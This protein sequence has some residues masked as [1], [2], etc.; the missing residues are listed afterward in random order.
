ME[1]I[2]RMSIIKMIVV[3]FSYALMFIQSSDAYDNVYTHPYINE[4]A[5]K[6]HL[7]V[8]T[9]LKETVGLNDGIYTKFGDKRIWE[10][11]RDGGIQEDEPEWRCF[12][13]FHD[14]LNASWDDAGL[15]SLYK[16]MIYWAQ[17]PDQALLTGTEEQYAKTFRSLG[18]LMHLVSDAALP[19]HVRNDAHPKFFEKIT[20][21]DD[22]DPYESWVG[23]NHKKIKEMEYERFTVDQAIFDM[24]VANTSAPSPV[25]ALWD[26]DE[27][28]SDGSNM[29]DDSNKTIGLAEYT[30]ANFWTEDTFP[31]KFNSGNYPH[32]VL[33]DTNYD[34]NVW[35]NPKQVDAEDGVTDKRIYFSKTSDAVGTPFLAAG[36][37]YWQLY[38]WNKPEVDDTF[39]LDEK[40]YE[41]YAKKLIPRAIGYSAALLDYFFR[42]TMD[43]KN[44]SVNY[45]TNRTGD[46]LV[47]SAVNFEATN[48]TPSPTQP[49]PAVEPMQNGTLDLVCRYTPPSGG[50]MVYEVVK[51]F[52]TVV[53]E[54]DAINNGYVSLSIP[55]D[56][57]IP[58]DALDLNFTL[59]YRGRLG[60]ETDAVAAAAIPIALNSRIAYYH[61]PG[62]PPNLSNVYASF[63]DGTDER[64]ITGNL[65]KGLWYFE[66]AWSPD[67]TRMA[68]S[69]QTCG[70]TGTDGYCVDGFTETIEIVD[71]ETLDEKTTISPIDP[72]FGIN[73][74][75]PLIS[76]AFSRDS[77]KITAIVDK[78]DMGFNGIIVYDLYSGNWH[79]LNNFE[80]WNRKRVNGSAPAWSPVR[81]EILYYV[82]QQQ[83]PTTNEM[84]FDRDIYLINSDGSDN[85]WLT[86]DD[87]TN[88]QPSWSPGG[89]WFVFA[90]N[91]DGEGVMDIWMMDREGG[92]LKK[93]RDC[94]AGCYH[95]NFSP[96]GLRLA[97]EESG[98][99]YSMNLGG[100]DLK[101]LTTLGD[102]TTAPAWSPYLRVPTLEVEV[103]V[104]TVNPGEPVTL[105]WTS[106][107]ADLAELNDGNGTVSIDTS[108]TM[109]FYPTETKTYTIQVSGL[110]GMVTQA[111]AI[112]VITTPPFTP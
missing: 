9:I 35:L 38:M 23:N 80:F 85:R 101:A 59:V 37:W 86:D 98:D 79:Y 107:F 90:S 83:D 68:I 99:I 110:G 82:H 10:L 84:V 5:V 65:D 30:N 103:S 12:R 34:E 14:P 92:N 106:E 81:D 11:I 26:H 105:S 3:L 25:S 28:N 20:I 66:P 52:Y 104:T 19:A 111:V 54:N 75:L 58:I 13:H 109:I 89:D 44:L 7:K 74:I 72:Y 102:R 64:E 50:D 93:L 61:Q 49:E 53:D 46:D 55:L 32:P 18:H 67:G 42:G 95:P 96:D 62:G 51:G 69:K 78:L 100:S 36:Y 27:Y 1:M 87:Y 45:D 73:P 63:A 91:R 88:I 6:E 43:V 31:W 15:L 76:P 33:E 2:M 112:D 39:L 8:N 108:D 16:S 70:A 48:S 22:S 56:H 21:Y 71:L 77:S 57:S 97:F 29:P 47:I 41:Q 17:T 24:A 4:K 40:C 94:T 60:N